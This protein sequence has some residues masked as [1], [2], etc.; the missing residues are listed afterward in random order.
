MDIACGAFYLDN[1][2]Q[3]LNIKGGADIAI[4]G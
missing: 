3:G 1:V 4:R 2:F